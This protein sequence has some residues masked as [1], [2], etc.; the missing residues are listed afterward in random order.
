MR[1][2]D[3]PKLITLLKQGADQNARDAEG[4][5]PLHEASV[6]TAELLLRR[7]ADVNARDVLG[8]TTPCREVYGAW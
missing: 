1:G 8:A 6:Y 2:D 4:K 3:L 5:T 7:C